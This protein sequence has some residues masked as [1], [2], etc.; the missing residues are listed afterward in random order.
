MTKTAIA[1]LLFI[2]ISEQK[3]EDRIDALKK[4]F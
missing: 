2:D 1:I 3:K 4:I